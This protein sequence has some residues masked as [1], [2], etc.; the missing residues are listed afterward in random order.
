MLTL[1]AVSPS[2]RC[3]DGFRC[4]SNEPTRLCDPACRPQRDAVPALAPAAAAAAR[5]AAP[6]AQPAPVPHDLVDLTGQSDDDEVLIMHWSDVLLDMTP[7][8][9]RTR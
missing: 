5:A 8:S 2:G 4:L 6:A 7:A 9:D 3:S 1:E